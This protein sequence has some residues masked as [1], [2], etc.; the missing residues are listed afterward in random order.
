MELEAINGVLSRSYLHKGDIGT[1]WRIAI[2]DQGCN[3]ALK[4][5][6]ASKM[7]A[8]CFNGECI[9]PIT[10]SQACFSSSMFQRISRKKV[11]ELR[12]A[13]H[14]LLVIQTLTVSSVVT[15]QTLTNESSTSRCVGKLAP[16]TKALII[17]KGGKSESK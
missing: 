13:A 12:C 9:S 17:D 16:N 1:L 11:S 15:V 4:Q 10:S 14:C 8:F 3:D 7:G 6:A 2:L 5:V